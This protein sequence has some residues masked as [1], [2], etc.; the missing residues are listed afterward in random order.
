MTV[1]DW[2][3]IEEKYRRRRWG[4]RQ[5]IELEVRRQASPAPSQV[6]I[7]LSWIGEKDIWRR[8]DSRRGVRRGTSERELAALYDRRNRITHEGD[9]YGRGQAA[10]TVNE[11]EVV[12]RSVLAIVSALDSETSGGPA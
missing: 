12:L 10:I 5:V 6:G 7:L 1:G 9:R 3:E 2:L 4:L 11:A 8:I